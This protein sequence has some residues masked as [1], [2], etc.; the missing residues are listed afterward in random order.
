MVLTGFGLFVLGVGV[1]LT[2]VEAVPLGFSVL[3][4]LFASLFL[5]VSRW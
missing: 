1:A 2:P 5:F 4:S 3:I